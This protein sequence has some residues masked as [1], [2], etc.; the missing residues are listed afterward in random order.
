M[1]EK[2]EPIIMLP[3]LSNNQ[4]PCIPNSFL[5]TNRFDKVPDTHIGKSRVERFGK[6]SYLS[7]KPFECDLTLPLPKADNESFKFNRTVS[8]KMPPYEDAVKLKF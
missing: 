5:S 8:H 1:P 3:K 7:K 2:P 6:H 4:E